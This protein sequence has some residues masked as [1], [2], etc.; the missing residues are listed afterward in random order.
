MLMAI[1]VV[2]SG[3]L[4]LLSSEDISEGA[5]TITIVNETEKDVIAIN[6]S[7]DLNI[8]F[9][10]V[11]EFETLEIKYIIRMYDHNGVSQSV[12]LISP[13]DGTITNNTPLKVNVKA[14]SV[15]GQ[16]TVKITFTEK[17]DDGKATDIVREFKFTAVKPITLSAT[18]ENTGDVDFSNLAVYFVIDGVRQDDSRKLVN[19]KAGDRTTVSYDWA[20]E[21]PSSG[22]HRFYI[23]SSNE[24]PGD[25]TLILGD[26]HTF[27]IGGESNNTLSTIIAGVLLVFAILFAVYVF[28]KPVKNYGKPKARR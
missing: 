13:R 7:L 22:S 15:P 21:R 4:M 2:A 25:G 19:V 18:V 10:E 26:S 16:Y 24:L 23:E 28:R 27:Y 8:T 9:Q 12:S 20:S 17:I 11:D 3:A 14:P 5:P 1:M 6:G